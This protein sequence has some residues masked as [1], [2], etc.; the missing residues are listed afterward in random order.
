MLATDLLLGALIAVE[1]SLASAALWFAGIEVLQFFRRK[2]VLQASA[3]PHADAKVF[4]RSMLRWWALLGWARA[5]VVAIA[6]VY[7]ESNLQVIVTMV[8][9]GLAAGSVATSGGEVRLMRAWSAPALGS[10]VLAWAAQFDWQGVTLAVL[11]FGLGRLLVGY[12]ELGGKQGRQL[13]DYAAEL[14]LERDRVREANVALERAGAQ[15]RAERDRAAEANAAKTRVLASVSHDLRQPLFALSLNAS[16]LGDLLERLDDPYLARIEHGLKRSLVQCRAL[17]DQLVDF[18]RLESGSVDIRWQAVELG[19]LLLL[20]APQY[21]STAQAA[22]LSWRL[23]PGALPVRVWTDPL[24]LERLLGNLLQN[25]VKFSREGEVGMR[26]HATPDAERVQLEVFDSG[27]GIPVAEQQ[28]VFEEFYQLDNP[29][30]DRARGLGLGLSIVQRLSTLLGVGLRLESAEGQGC[31]F[32]L[33]LPVSRTPRAAAPDNDVLR[34]G[35]V[36]AQAG[37]VLAIDDEPDLL[38]DLCTLLGG[39]GYTVVTA[40]DADEACAR[41]VEMA[42]DIV[43]ADFRLRNDCTGLAAIQAVRRA[44]GRDVPAMIITGDTA[45]HRIAEASASGLRVLHKP[46]DG[47]ALAQALLETLDEAR[48]PQPGQG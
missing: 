8:I 4:M 48:E 20:M 15:L 35:S 33:D 16:A 43:L 45:P 11:I 23:E 37:V 39:R 46:L 22:G 3:D 14:E 25:A 36:A 44:L 9:I 12:V 34:P 2:V 38:N 42:P 47:C 41:A 40:E 13:I 29:S 31:R 28:R 32:M 17:L 19:P 10:L 6:F 7:G 5:A 1:V 30:R 26:V 24:L 21:Q 27:P 18:S